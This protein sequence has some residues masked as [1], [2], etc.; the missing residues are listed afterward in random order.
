MKI[1]NFPF[2]AFTLACTLLLSQLASAASDNTEKLDQIIVS[3]SRTPLTINQLGSTVSVISRDEIERR[4]ARNVAELLRSV[5]GFAVSRT[6]VSGSQTQVRVRGAEANH[7][8][9]MIDGVRANDP[10]T[11]DEFRW[12]YLATGNIERIEIVRGPQSSLWGSDAV[13]A[14][15]HII[16][17]DGNS[18]KGVDGYVEG[19]S[20]NTTNA[21]LNA[22]FGDNNWSVTGSIEN[23]QTDGQNI[24][25]TGDEKDGAELTTAALS[26]RIA[27]NDVVT[28]RA[29]LRAID[30][31]SQFDPVDFF[32]TGLPVDGDVATDT[33]NLYA[34]VGADISPTSGSV[35][36]H[37]NVR[38]FESDNENLVDGIEDSSTASDRLTFTYQAD[39]QIGDNK[40]SLGLE[41]DKTSFEQR[42][43]VG[44]GDPNQDQ[45]IDATSI[46]G[47]YQ[48]LAQKLTWILSSRFDK[49]SDFDDA[50]NGRLALSY[51][52]AESTTLRGSVGSGQKNP[53]FIERYGFFTAGHVGNP[54]LKP[55]RSIS[56]EI[57]ARREFAQGSAALDVA[58]FR[59]DLQDEINGFV[60]DPVTFLSTSE[61]MNGKS[62]RSGAEVSLRWS[63]TDTFDIN[64][65]Y[66][67]TDSTAPDFAGKD[68]RELRR[69]RHSGGI[70]ADFQTL[71]RRFSTT[72][73]ADFGGER[74]DI[75]FPP[76]PNPAEIVTLDSYWLVDLTAQFR[77]TDSVTVFAK[78]TNLLDENY[79]QVFGYRTLGRASY[80]GVRAAFGR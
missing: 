43:A 75:F 59:Q 9:V 19:G 40:A 46:V 38:Y 64:A 31:Y 22:A 26:A 70:G 14:V 51:P 50:L 47:E 57:G 42:G 18:G 78:A 54:D 7:I 48:G 34:N 62:K 29:G 5:P 35:S 49:N 72:L 37:L 79:E 66:T 76:W 60:F 33:T 28:L 67:Y 13:A 20:F 44:F 41:Q 61:N 36:H 73:T 30:A 68:S 69:P 11:G 8:L 23:H 1:G 17:R 39:F 12:E 27:A 15:V 32:V 6:G 65:H 77:A 63:A 71:D 80:V 56:W 52:L 74:T 10:A 55:E 21:A 24:S 16:T 45:E 4:E 53:T 58:V 3:G 2:A 25:R